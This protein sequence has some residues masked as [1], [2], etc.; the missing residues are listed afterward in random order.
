MLLDDLFLVAPV[1]TAKVEAIVREFIAARGACLK[2]NPTVPGDV[3]S[4]AGFNRSSPGT[5]YRAS[6]VLT[7]W[8]KP[9]LH[10]LLDEREN[11][12]EFELNGSERSD[13][14]PDFFAAKAGHFTL[15]NGVIKGRWSRR[16][17]RTVQLLTGSQQ[18]PARPVLSWSGEIA[19]QLALLRSRIF[20]RLTAGKNR[21]YHRWLRSARARLLPPP[22]VRKSG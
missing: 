3:P 6:T 14:Y 12:W 21:R 4:H 16:A 5:A 1:D 2:L 8:S 10:D 20:L 9:V 11:A 19:Y 15:V 22:A 7:L 13:A 18:A 17:L